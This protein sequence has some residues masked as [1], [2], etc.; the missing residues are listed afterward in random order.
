MLEIMLAVAT[1]LGGFSALWFFWDRLS[2]LPS[3]ER[4]LSV[5]S[6]HPTSMVAA[7]RRGPAGVRRYLVDWLVQD[8]DASGHHLGQ[9]GRKANLREERHYQTGREVLSLKRKR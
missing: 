8:Q 6:L 7:T 4:V 1:L 5:F 3:L 9:F 2:T